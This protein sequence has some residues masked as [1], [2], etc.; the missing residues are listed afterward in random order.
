MMEAAPP[1]YC[2]HLV[3]HSVDKARQLC[4]CV[5][6]SFLASQGGKGRGDSTM[7]G[8]HTHQRNQFLAGL[9]GEFDP[10]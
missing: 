8:L 6:S 9:P 2:Q 7:V 1:P 5:I 4:P 3:A 10:G